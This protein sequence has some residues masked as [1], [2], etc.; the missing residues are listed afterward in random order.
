LGCQQIHAP[1]QRVLQDPLV[2][3]DWL[4]QYRVTVTWAPNFAYSLVNDNADAMADKK[5]DL[6]SMRFILNAG[7]AIVAKTARRF[8]EL[9]HPYGLA[10]TAM[11]PA[12]GMSETSSA[13]VYSDTF[14][15]ESTT[16]EQTFVEV[17]GS[18]PGLMMRIVDADNQVVAAETIGRLQVKGDMVTLGYYAQPE[19][20]RQVLSEEGWFDTGDLGFLRQGNLTLTGRQ[21]DLI[22]INGANLHNHEIETVVETVADVE[23]SFTAACAVRLQDSQTD[24]LAVFFHSKLIDPQALLKQLQEIRQTVGAQMGVNP[25]YLIPLDKADIPKTAIGKI[26]RTQLRKR[27]EAGEFDPIIKRIDVLSANDNTLPDWFYQRHWFPKQSRSAGKFTPNSSILVF[28]DTLG[29]GTALCQRLDQEGIPHIKVSNA[30][31]FEQFGPHHYGISL[32][33]PQHYHQLVASLRSAGREVTTILHLGAYQTNPEALDSRKLLQDAQ[34]HGTYSMLFLVQALAQD[35]DASSPM[36]LMAVTANLQAIDSNE[37]TLCVHG[38]LTGLLHTLPLEL[39]WL[40]CQHIDLPNLGDSDQHADL[41]L[42]ELTQPLVDTEIAYRQ[43]QRWAAAFAPIEWQSMPRQAIAFKTGGMYLLTGGLGG[44]AIALARSILQHCP[45]KLIL[46]GRT[47]LPPRHEWP[48]HIEN[49]TEF[50][51]KIRRLQGIEALTKDVVY[52]SADIC[53]LD[54]LEAIVTEAEQRWQ[55]SLD[56][57]L[58]LASEGKNLG[59]HWQEADQHLMTTESFETIEWM[60]NAK[61]YGSYVLGQ[62]L[63][64]NRPDALFVGFSSV[65]ALFGGATFGAY[66]AANSFL[67][68]FCHYQ[69]THGHPNTYSI[70]WSMWQATGMSQGASDSTV[71]ISRQMGFHVLSKSQGWRSLQACLSSPPGQYVVGLDR[72]KP[73]IR[74]VC[75]SE[76]ETLHKMA[77]FFTVKD[78]LAIEHSQPLMVKLEQLTL[79]DRFSNVSRCSFL[80]VNE[81]PRLANGQVDKSALQRLDL[82]SDQGQE[83][84]APQNPTEKKVSEIWSELLHVDIVGRHDNFFELGGHSLLA[85]Q[86]ISHIRQHLNVDLSLFKIFELP[87]ITALSN[88]IIKMKTVRKEDS[89]LMIK[90]SARKVYRRKVSPKG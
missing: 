75:F 55:H 82:R 11:R 42:D 20:T 64:A 46:I 29:L 27:L 37:R 38:T 39:E 17:G 30:S 63:L 77:A 86:M 56:G 31:Q 8:L 18:I 60:W 45:A 87:T 89:S 51:Y 14:S 41:I 67:D 28:M 78:K 73:N 74:K 23:V 58:H 7:E 10:S 47:E 80:Q 19:L 3:I 15:R 85:T 54:A 24:Q 44:M 4:H 33:Q 40:S 49:E 6:S 32:Q 61:V 48:Y 34:Y 26:Q 35:N 36:R 59:E 22:I 84:T 52:H 69:R 5:W 62:Q 76:C 88:E 16:D 68:H 43:G 13:V 25:T 9:L 1:T 2:W 70:N 81:L 71:A 53:D 79:H 57:V 83:D 90:P 66:A 50:A 21:K 12:W 72:H 65:N